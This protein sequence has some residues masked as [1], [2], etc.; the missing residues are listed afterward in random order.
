[1]LVK[2]RP[3]TYFYDALPTAKTVRQLL[4][5]GDVRERRSVTGVTLHYN[6]AVALI[7]T[8]SYQLSRSDRISP[9]WRLS[10][11]E[12]AILRPARARP[13]VIGRG[14]EWGWWGR[15]GGTARRRSLVAL[16]W[17][18]S[19]HYDSDLNGFYLG[20]Q[21]NHDETILRNLWY[22]HYPSTVHSQSQSLLKQ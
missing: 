1:M 19:M 11:D 16:D 4:S 10:A 14:A 3:H 20:S 12:C 5:V 2:A 6:C 21:K 17:L 22:I 9:V 15:S 8:I 18:L 7:H 13:V